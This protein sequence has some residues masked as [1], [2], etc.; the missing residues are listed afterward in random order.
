MTGKDDG[1][2][3]KDHALVLYSDETMAALLDA[4]AK[5]DQII[6][7][8]GIK[9]QEKNT[10]FVLKSGVGMGVTFA[11]GG[12]AC[13]VTGAS[14]IAGLALIGFGVA[15]AG[16]VFAIATGSQVKLEEFSNVARNYLPKQ[17]ENSN[18]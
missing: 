10:S 14:I 8:Y 15:C 1:S 18:E 17:D 7:Y 11:A 12:V 13:L 2:S 5:P 3:S 6:E 9:Q 4:E 16:A